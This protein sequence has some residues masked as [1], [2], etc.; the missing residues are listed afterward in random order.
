MD[1]GFIDMSDQ[2]LEAIWRDKGNPRYSKEYIDSVYQERGNRRLTYPDLTPE[3]E[4]NYKKIKTKYKT[5]LNKE[6][7]RFFALDY[8][9]SIGLGITAIAIVV[10]NENYWHLPIEKLASIMN[11]I[12]Y[13]F[14]TVF[15]YFALIFPGF[16]NKFISGW[17]FALYLSIV[18]FSLFQGYL[19]IYRSIGGKEIS[20]FYSLVLY[21]LVT[22]FWA[23]ITDKVISYSTADR[24]V[25]N[26][27]PKT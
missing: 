15:I 16:K 5:I 19:P 7:N 13:V 2:E 24:K 18:V 12:F 23:Y 1:D 4:E 8:V 17:L 22:L 11:P 27:D 3:Q 25:G 9:T 20:G 26:D 10:L 14:L 21:S 6:R